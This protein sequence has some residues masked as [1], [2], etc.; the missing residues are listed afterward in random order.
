MEETCKKVNVNQGKTA[1][2]SLVPPQKTHNPPQTKTFFLTTLPI[3]DRMFP[4]MKGGMT[5]KVWEA[6]I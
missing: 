5:E 4:M 2:P 1:L 6:L 3:L